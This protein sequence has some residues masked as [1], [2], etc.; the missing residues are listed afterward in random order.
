[1]LINFYLAVMSSWA[2]VGNAG[3][4]D[5]VRSCQNAEVKEH[6]SAQTICEFTSQGRLQTAKVRAPADTQAP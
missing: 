1:M 5:N 6:R 3:A 2:T 4:D